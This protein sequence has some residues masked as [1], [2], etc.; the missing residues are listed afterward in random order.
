MRVYNG[1]PDPFNGNAAA[2]CAPASAKLPDTSPIAVLCRQV[3]QATTDIDGALGFTAPLQSGIPAREQ[4]WTYNEFGQVLTHDGPRTDINDITTYEYYPSTNF[5]GTDPN[6][7]GYT[8]GD[9][10]QVTNAVGQV[11]RYTLYDKLGQLLETQDANGVVTRYTY[12]AR[13]RMTSVNVGGQ[14][15]LYSYW[16]TGLI[17]Q[18]TQPDASWVFHEYDD[19]QRLVKASDNLGNSVSYVLDNMG[20]RKEENFADPSGSLRRK[21]LRDIDALGRVQLITGRE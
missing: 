11:T 15:T 1:Q 7:I 6:A 16:P 13:Q 17:R 18:V 5:T 19:A 9:L 8:R 21:L 4:R 12:D 20:N 10:K 3:E 14:A 2:S